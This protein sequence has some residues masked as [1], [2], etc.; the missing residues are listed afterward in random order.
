MEVKK[1]NKSEWE[2][3]KPLLHT[4]HNDRIIYVPEGFVTDFASVPSFLLWLFPKRGADEL[5][6]VVHDYLYVVGGSESDRKFADKEMYCI[7]KNF[8]AG[9]LRRSCMFLA[10]RLFGWLFF[11]YK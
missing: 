4:A 10:V 2:L 5:A 1:L 7:Q 3:T 9:F 6:F 8:G 11:P